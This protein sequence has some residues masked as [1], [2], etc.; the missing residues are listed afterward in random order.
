MDIS[1]NFDPK[2]NFDYMYAKIKEIGYDGL[3]FCVTSD[4]ILS[5]EYALHGGHSPCT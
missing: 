4:D 3:D 2:D 1:V 5:D